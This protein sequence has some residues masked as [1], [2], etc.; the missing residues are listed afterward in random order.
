MK[1]DGT[2]QFEGERSDADEVIPLGPDAAEPEPI[3]TFP[4]EMPMRIIG[5]N[6][7][8]MIADVLKAFA[9]NGV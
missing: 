3:L 6:D 7:P 1:E 4:C 2:N 5:E 9:A 8:E